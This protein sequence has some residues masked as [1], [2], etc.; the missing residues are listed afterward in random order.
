MA[1]EIRNPKS[2]IRNP[3]SD[4]PAAVETGSPSPPVPNSQQQAAIDAKSVSVVLSAGAGCG[5]TSVLTDRFLSHLAPG[6]H[7]AELS[8]LVAI[9]FTERAAREMR[10]R[11][12]SKC[13][14]RLRTEPASEAERWLAIL[15]ELDTARISTIHS[16]CSSLLRSNAVDAGLDPKFGLLDETL[17]LAFLQQAVKAGL[18][19]L[20]AVNDAEAAELVFEY[21]LGR[22]Q[23]LLAILVQER[24]RIDFADWEHL[25]ARELAQRWDERWHKAFVPALLREAAESEPARKTLDLLGKFVPDNA[26]MCERR[27]LLLEQIPR[28]ADGT[29]PQELLESLRQNARVQGGGSEKD[30][31]NDDVYHAVRDVLADLRTLLEK[32]QAQ[33]DYDPEHLL[34]GAEVGLCAVRAAARV[35]RAYDLRKA[36]A[37]LLDF[38]DLLLLSRNLVR[39]HP[40]V[41]RRAQA[42]IRLLMVDEFQDTDPI[43]DDIVRLLCGDRLLDGGL[44]VVG[45]AKQSIYRFRRAEPRVFHDLRQ[46][47]PA[48]G[49]LPLSVNFRSQPEILA[50]VNAVF[51][52]AL[53]SEYEPLT[54]HVTQQTPSPCVEFLFSVAGAEADA[55]AESGAD[56]DVDQSAPARRRREGDWIARRITQ[57]LGDRD[58]RV[59]DR[60]AGTGAEKLRRVKRRDI[61]VLFRAM[62]DVR[63][64]EEALRQYGLD[65]YVVG[66]RAFFAQQE[67]FDVVNLC[68]VLDDVDNQAALV[69]VLRSP[70]FCLSD[71]AVCAL[72]QSPAWALS[73][74]PPAHLAEHDQERIQFA[75]RVLAELR[76]KKDR[77]PIAA[78]LNLAID[79]TGYDASLLTEFLGER[80]LANLRKLV[81]MARQFDQSGLFTLADFVGRLRDA[82]ADE[83]HEPLAATHPESSDVIRLMSIHQAKG[84]EFPVVF[85]ADT[86]RQGRDLAPPAHFDAEV[87]P[88]VSLPEKFGERRDHPGM[89]MF[90]L[91]ER[92]EDLAESLRLFY[93]ATT[94]AADLLILSA[95]LKQAGR[96]T[97]PWL[98]L[99]SERFD[100]LTGQ[101]RQAPATGGVSIIAKYGRHLPQIRIHHSAPE[102]IE[103]LTD[104]APKRPALNHFRESLEAADPDPFPET[105]RVFA[106]DRSA[107]RRFSVSEI[108]AI[109]AELRLSACGQPS[110]PSRHE[111]HSAGREA[112]ASSASSSAFPPLHK[113]AEGGV[114]ANDA[115][116]QIVGALDLGA[117]E[118]LGTLVHAGLERLDFKN[119]QEI[120][121]LIDACAVASLA[122]FDDKTRAVAITCVDNVL[123]SPLGAELAAARQIHRE[124]EFLLTFPPIRKGSQTPADPLIR[125]G[126]PHGER[127]TNTGASAR[128]ALRQSGKGRTGQLVIDFDGPPSSGDLSE[129]ATVSSDSIVI[130]GTI[131]CLFESADGQWKIVDYKTG[132]RESTTPAA[133]L[134]A[135]YEIQLGLYTL[136]VEQLVHRVP[137]RIELAFVRQG[138]DRVVFEPTP[139]RLA[140]IIARVARAI[141]HCRVP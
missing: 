31:E 110:V 14:E 141:V 37:G 63:Y 95:N 24:Y 126:S 26:V 5:K 48:A 117:A 22:A 42:G 139:E 78:L 56:D 137:D 64:Y 109:D 25:T 97:N 129:I 8:H 59:R 34:R 88:L 15:R 133:E 9:T 123:R 89:R 134:P 103:L 50:F 72:G 118:Q 92:K 20:L 65:Y 77:I 76:E 54:A 107:R 61:V 81:E 136:A 11:V 57:L 30:W 7:Q 44:F 69:G 71:D 52:G 112:P 27:L 122:Q 85:V 98:Q 124:I 2:E 32:L 10:D 101:P 41:R 68:Q 12:R 132:I 116:E 121:V 104:D 108:E 100:L 4:N 28:L 13:L 35:G 111:S 47:I 74:D 138:V 140:E 67:I 3:P 40:E 21:G 83:T 75:G 102:P 39:D 62:S 120:A 55:S 94:R 86:D 16:F 1:K 125:G 131:D 49:R 82:V 119:P 79:R 113:G 106:P 135:D 43:Q 6:D 93:V 18:H 99:V 33:L 46:E 36:E 60:N 91:Q 58:P 73:R 80:K 127:A 90:R 114:G 70:F 66:G 128:S 53:G 29:D 130:S 84:L 19:E 17:G 96:A 51:D 38:D 115:A 45:D 105:L 23:D 87:G